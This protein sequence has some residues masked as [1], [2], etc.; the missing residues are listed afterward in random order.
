[1]TPNP[2]PAQLDDTTVTLPSDREI[3]ITR[4]FDAPRDLVF[5]AMTTPENIRQWYGPRGTVLGECKIDLRVGGAWRF[6]MRG[7]DGSQHAFSGVYREIQAPER[8]VQTWNYESIPGAE[9]VETMTL[10]DVGGKTQMTTHVQ[11]KSKAS[12]DGHLQSGMEGGMRETLARLEELVS[13]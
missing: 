2:K 12:R 7:P 5:K 4:T 13:R 8:I 6:V 1:M 3:L 9:T 11:H 10:R